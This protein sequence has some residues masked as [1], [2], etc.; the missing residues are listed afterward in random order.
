MANDVKA[1]MLPLRN[2]LDSDE[3]EPKK[4]RPKLADS[5][6]DPFP[7]TCEEPAKLPQRLANDQV[8]KPLKD[9]DD[10]TPEYFQTLSC[11]NRRLAAEIENSLVEDKW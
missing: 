8:E 6:F 10:R 1:V 4:L 5:D 9:E 2:K 7:L 3:A 11:R